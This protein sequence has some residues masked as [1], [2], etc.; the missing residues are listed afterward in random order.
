MLDIGGLAVNDISAGSR[1][2]SGHK[3]PTG[4]RGPPGAGNIFKRITDNKGQLRAIGM[5]QELGYPAGEMFLFEVITESELLASLHYAS[6][7]GRHDRYMGIA[8]RNLA[9]P[10]YERGH[11]RED[12]VE[13][14]ARSGTML[15]YEKR[16]RRAKKEF[17][18]LERV[19]IP[20][21][22]VAR[23]MLDDLCIYHRR[24][25]KMLWEDA[26][27]SLAKIADE[28]GLKAK[29]I[30]R[31]DEIY[32]VPAG[33]GHGVATILLGLEVWFKENDAKVSHFRLLMQAPEGERGIVAYGQV[34]DDPVNGEW[35]RHAATL[36]HGKLLPAAVDAAL[37][38]GATK[39][40]WKERE[41]DVV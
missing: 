7:I 27:R 11:G 32:R 21:G 29:H 34:G 24:L 14:N 20:L 36:R 33:L 26:A 8:K 18:R 10:D 19:M 13:K 1:F 12:E 6:V 3:R 37:L 28:F 35:I 25:P 22:R 39:R 17:D 41:N 4:R 38:K 16:A 31:G 5:N 40:G 30:G 2:P 15:A 9:S 23:D